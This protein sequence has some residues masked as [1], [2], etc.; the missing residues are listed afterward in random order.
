MLEIKSTPKSPKKPTRH[1]SLS[2]ITVAIPK[3]GEDPRSRITATTRQ[4]ESL[5]RLTEAHARM[6]FSHFVEIQDVDEA[7]RLMHEAIRTSATD[8]LMGKID[9]DLL[10]TGAGQQQGDCAQISRG[11]S[12]RWLKISLL[13]A[14]C[15]GRTRSSKSSRRSDRV[16]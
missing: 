14:V 16:L 15:S 3:L 9:I 1:S 12:L 13:V 5:I 2:Y 7:P 8:L 4:L 6:R 10:N 11:R